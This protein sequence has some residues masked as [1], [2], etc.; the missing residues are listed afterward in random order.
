MDKKQIWLILG[1]AVVLLLFVAYTHPELLSITSYQNHASF[2]SQNPITIKLTIS[3]PEN[4]PYDTILFKMTTGWEAGSSGVSLGCVDGTYNS[5]SDDCR[6][7]G[8]QDRCSG[9]PCQPEDARCNNQVACWK[10][11]Y[12]S[13]SIIT[14]KIGDDTVFQQKSDGTQLAGTNSE[15]TNLASYFNKYIP[16]ASEATITMTCTADANAG[17]ITIS[18]TPS[19]QIH[20]IQIIIPPVCTEGA[21][22]A[23]Q[24]GTCPGVQTCSNNAW[25]DC[26][27]TDAACGVNPANET[28]T[29]T[30]T[31][32]AHGYADY[33]YEKL[34]AFIHAIQSYF[35]W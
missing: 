15:T 29:Q 14:C 23:C 33:I 25:Q 1:I 17:S 22:K 9:N 16:I 31:T 18:G 13:S 20:H 21:T 3:E 10:Y 24:S 7:G 19:S 2:S 8:Y 28:T 27:K 32:Y 34:L 11:N 5:G 4:Q 30:A 12:I 6:R 26:V 35:R